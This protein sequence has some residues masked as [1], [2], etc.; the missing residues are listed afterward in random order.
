MIVVAH[1]WDIM[2]VLPLNGID[3]PLH[4]R[5]DKEYQP[6]PY[7]VVVEGY[8]NATWLIKSCPDTEKFDLSKDIF[9]AVHAF[10]EDTRA[11]SLG[12]HFSFSYREYLFCFLH[13][14]HLLSD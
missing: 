11:A 12:D 7:A 6:S 4:Q 3:L 2:I 10:G 8:G 1:L 14:I 9:A 5:P 13:G